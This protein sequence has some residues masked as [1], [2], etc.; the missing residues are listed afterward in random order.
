M[1]SSRVPDGPRTP[2]HVVV[3]NGGLLHGQACLGQC[4]V[5]HLTLAGDGPAVQRGQGTLHGEH[6]GQTV[7]GDSASRGGGPPGK[8]FMCRSPLAA[9]ATDA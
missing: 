3:G 8:P 1:P 2:A 9:S 7:T 6:P 4:G 5:D